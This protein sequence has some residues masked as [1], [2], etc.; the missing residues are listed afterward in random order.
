MMLQV[1]NKVSRD[2]WE[3]KKPRSRPIYSASR[4][5]REKFIKA[6][7]V[8]KEFLQEL[9]KSEKPVSLVSESHGRGDSA[10]HSN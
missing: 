3:A 8:D 6:K 7:Y 10:K 9:P 4:E 2:L 1:G 5:D